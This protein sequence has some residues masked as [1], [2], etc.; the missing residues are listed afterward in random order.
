MVRSHA[1]LP[2]ASRGFGGRA[3][4]AELLTGIDGAAGRPVRRRI[5]LITNRCSKP[6]PTGGAERARA[7]APRPLTNQGVGISPADRVSIVSRST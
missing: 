5:V 7:L 1:A 3:G 6:H 2:Y 4:R